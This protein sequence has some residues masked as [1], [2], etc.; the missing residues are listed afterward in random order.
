M[1]APSRF[2][3][4]LEDGGFVAPVAGL[5]L[6]DR[7]LL[8]GEYILGG[9]EASSIKNHANPARPLTVQGSG[10]VYNAHSV[11]LKSGSTGYGFL[12]NI[13]HDDQITLIVIRKPSTVT[14]TVQCVFCE[15]MTAGPWFGARQFGAD[16]YFNLG[17]TSA[18]NNGAHRVRPAAGTIF[19]EAGVSPAL[20]NPQWL[21]G[22][23]GTLFYYSGGVQ[24]AAVSPTLASWATRNTLTQICIGGSAIDDTVTTGV[25]EV[26]FVALYNK[27]L[28]AA[29]IDEAYQNI[30]AWYADLGVT[31][32]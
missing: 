17:E 30:V 1:T 11:T 13:I 10:M 15:G 8:V 27:P 29:G 12:T 21:T 26:F 20:Y 31:V 2:A 9:N 5:R 23:F 18:N 28:T 7:E 14:S 4:K 24:Q 19:F 32:V 25:F 3:L 16:N 22:G 6:P